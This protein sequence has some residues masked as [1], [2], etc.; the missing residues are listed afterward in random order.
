MKQLRDQIDEQSEISSENGQRGYTE[1]EKF[2]QYGG[3][4]E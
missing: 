2:D 1:E 3:D 4:D